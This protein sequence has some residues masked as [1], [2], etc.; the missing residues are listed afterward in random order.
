[1]Y[2]HIRS[3]VEKGNIL[4]GYV[5]GL[6]I[7]LMG[8]MLF[9]EVVCRYFFRSPTIWAQEMSIYLF[10]W[11]MLAGGAYTLQQGKHVRIDL[12]IEHL[13]K[14]TQQILEMITSVAGMLFCAVITWQAYEMIKSSIGYNK[15]SATLLRIPMWIPQMALLLGFA[16]LTFQF[17]IIIIDRYMSVFAKGTEEEGKPC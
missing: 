14:R 16:L 6:G 1:M 10:M 7:L 15:V 9:Y 3:I 12:I 11:T 2:K 4:L 8:L 17:A 13:S 5:S